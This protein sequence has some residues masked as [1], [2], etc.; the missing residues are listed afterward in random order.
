MPYK[1]KNKT[2]ENN[3]V[4]KLARRRRTATFIKEYKRTRPCTDCGLYFYDYPEVLEF[5]HEGNKEFTISDYARQDKVLE[6]V[7]NEIGK[8]ELVCANCHRI[9]TVKK[10]GRGNK[11]DN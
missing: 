11:G 4:N 3:R 7:I 1:D 8:C 9:R 5:D 2:R 10:Y 6:E